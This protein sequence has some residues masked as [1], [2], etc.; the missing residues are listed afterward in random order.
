MSTEQKHVA[1]N[2]WLVSEAGQQQGPYSLDELKQLIRDA[3]LSPAALVWTPGMTDWKAWDQ[4]PELGGPKQAPPRPAA[5]SPARQ[6]RVASVVDR[7]VMIE[8]LMFRKMITPLIIQIVFWLGIAGVAIASLTTLISAVGLGGWGGAIV[9][10]FM[11]LFIFVV[12]ALTVRIYCE[13]LIVA[14]RILETLT[15]IRSQLEKTSGTGG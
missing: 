6:P 13:L 14:F 5:D 7:A 3:R 11:S 2:Q 9:G 8:Y 4:V 15:E 1:A 10:L 12:G